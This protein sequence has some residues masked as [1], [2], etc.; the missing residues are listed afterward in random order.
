MDGFF[1]GQR[2][3][4]AVRHGHRDRVSTAAD[5]RDQLPAVALVEPRLVN[6][7]QEH[8]V[9]TI[10]RVHLA[11]GGLQRVGVTG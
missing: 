2:I 3:R 8:H 11:E 9:L 5:D 7:E 1:A 10:D 4:A 6:G